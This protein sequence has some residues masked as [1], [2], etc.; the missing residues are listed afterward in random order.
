M[1]LDKPAL[2]AYRKQQR[3]P[4][5]HDPDKTWSAVELLNTEFP[6]PRWAV[7]GIVAEGV[8]LLAG[9]PKLG[10]SWMAL[11][12]ALA[13]AAGGRAF[14]RVQVEQGPVLYLALEDTP[15]RLQ[16]R[17]R[18]VLGADHAPAGLE[19][20]TCC[21][22]ISDGGGERIAKWLAAHPDA[23]LV[24]IDVLTRM[25]GRVSDRADRY[26]ADY[27]AMTEFKTIA[28]DYS[29]PFLV[30]HH[31]RKA[32]ADDFLDTVSGSHGLAG[33]ADAVSVLKRSRNSP[34]AIL[35]VTGRDIE[36][37]KYALKFSSEIGT[38]ALLEGSA[39]DYEMSDEW[40][41]ILA[42]VR[43]TEGIT[44]KQIAETSGVSHDV[45]KQLVRKMVDDG[46]LDTD[47][48]G[49]YFAP[50]TE[51]PGERSPRSPRSPA[52]EC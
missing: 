52:S 7:P 47:G 1:K 31:T 24:I 4:N 38:W 13:I 17:L 37:A 36:E 16:N 22:S 5:G 9:A 27:D 29:T 15:R 44:P 48:S 51:N 45:V 10:K 30:P 42:A 34:D 8:N 12:L 49:H 28:D 43:A 25:R 20:W 26:M 40:R 46:Q 23:R 2:G 50:P 11:N 39:D 21:E 41:Q 19:F 14:G 18:M 6:E 32:D 33:A 3:S 35:N